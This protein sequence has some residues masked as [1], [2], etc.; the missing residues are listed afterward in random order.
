MTTT[1]KLGIAGCIVAAVTAY[2]AYQG[3]ATSWKYYLTVD[4]CQA[5]VP[6]LVHQ[7]VRVNGKVAVG[8][9]NISKHGQ[10]ATF[11]IQGKE[12]QLPVV[13][14]G[15]LPDNLAED[16]D[17]VVEGRLDE[18]GV[19]QGEKVLTRCA[20]KYASEAKTASSA[21]SDKLSRGGRE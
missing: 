21:D 5:E 17:V 10:R 4:E 8:S 19:L 9:L 14:N 7:R 13:C 1:V 3:T 12:H 6:A 2:M 16:M 20:S 18:S 15:S 11:Q